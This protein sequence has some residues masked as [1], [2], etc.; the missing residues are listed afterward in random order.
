M[1]VQQREL[2]KLEGSDGN[3]ADAVPAQ[4]Q[5]LQGGAQL[6]QSAQLQHADFVVVQVPEHRSKVI[7]PQQ[8]EKGSVRLRPYSQVFHPQ[9]CREAVSSDLRDVIVA[10]IQ[11]F[12]GHQL[13]NPSAVYR[14]DLIVMSEEEKREKVRLVFISRPTASTC[15]AFPS[16][17]LGCVPSPERERARLSDQ[18]LCLRRERLAS[19]QDTGL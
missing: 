9:A 8:D 7:D 13:R 17:P 2:R 4:S 15:G 6:V 1:N 14:A 18:K 11:S 3:L 12:H 19:F 16:L 10:Q 5:D